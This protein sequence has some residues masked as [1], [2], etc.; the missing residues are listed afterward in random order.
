MKRQLD[1]NAIQKQ[2]FTLSYVNGV[3]VLLLALSIALCFGLWRD[4]SGQK[5]AYLHEID[6]LQQQARQLA[7]QN[8]PTEQTHYSK[9]E[10]NVVQRLHQELNIAWHSLL[11][12][13]ENVTQENVYL[14]QVVPD[15]KRHTVIL[16]GEANALPDV[17]AYMD[18]LAKSNMLADIYLQKHTVKQAGPQ[19]L[20]V[21][22]TISARWRDE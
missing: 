11:D 6:Q 19:P 21:E 22:F 4:F 14:L 3:N 7:S 9:E 20:N 18:G 1:L 8:K 13:L 12:A 10:L 2:P 5:V 17:F 16:M 15:P